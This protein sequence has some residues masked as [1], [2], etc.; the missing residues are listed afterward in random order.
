MS[1]H[2][3]S[4][5]RDARE[6][7]CYGNV[8]SDAAAD[9]FYISIILNRRLG[10]FLG[11][12]RFDAT[13]HRRIQTNAYRKWHSSNAEGVCYWLQ[14]TLPDWKVHCVNMFV[15]MFDTEAVLRPRRII[16]HKQKSEKINRIKKAASG[17]FIKMSGRRWTSLWEHAS[18]P[19]PSAGQEADAARRCSSGW[20]PRFE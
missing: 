20:R 17:A 5:G 15:G 16:I 7:N 11:S 6:L 4:W 2:D 19:P 18:L 1:W 8:F 12:L 14:C 10:S 9:H 3:E 13:V